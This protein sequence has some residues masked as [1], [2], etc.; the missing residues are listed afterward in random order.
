MPTQ[1][2]LTNVWIVSFSYLSQKFRCSV[3]CII[4][5]IQWLY[6][7]HLNISNRIGWFPQIRYCWNVRVSIHT[8]TCRTNYSACRVS[9]HWKIFMMILVFIHTWV[10]SRNSVSG[11]LASIQINLV[12]FT[13]LITLF[14][15][16]FFPRSIRLLLSI[17]IGHLQSWWLTQRQNME[18]MWQRTNLSNV[19][20]K[21]MCTSLKTLWDI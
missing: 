14:L 9:R 21:E 16:S 7:S 13:N 8:S 4:H 15:L 1:M 2:L 18:Y 10:H 17:I 11:T 3:I 12:I 5:I 20:L 6:H 19:Y